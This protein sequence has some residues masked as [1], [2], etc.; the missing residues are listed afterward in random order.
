MRYKGKN[1][2]DVLDLDHHEDPIS[3]W[4][5]FFL[6]P[7]GEHG[8]GS[9]F[10]KSLIEEIYK[11]SSNYGFD[12]K[13]SV[14]IGRNV[15]NK[16]M[17][18]RKNVDIIIEGVH[19][20]K[21][22]AIIIESKIYADKRNDFNYY[23]NIIDLPKEDKICILMTLVRET[24]L[25]QN[26][27]SIT[28]D[29]WMSRVIF[30]LEEFKSD[31]NNFYRQ[32]AL[33]LAKHIRDLSEKRREF[34]KR[35]Q[36]SNNFSN[37]RINK[38]RKYPDWLLSFRRTLANEISS[39]GVGFGQKEHSS[40]SILLQYKE[41][42]IYVFVQI[43]NVYNGKIAIGIAIKTDNDDTWHKTLQKL[44]PF[45]DQKGFNEFRPNWDPKY[46]SARYESYG[47]SKI[48]DKEYFEYK[49]S[50]VYVDAVK[51]AIV[52]LL[53]EDSWIEHVGTISILLSK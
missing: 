28:H 41:T 20:I 15:G 29:E 47:I 25:P 3:D 39:L 10:L 38:K 42:P 34:S 27:I 16:S 21:K 32:K 4:Y 24:T 45:S 44:N 49:S 33:M 22:K 35:Q 8:L 12:I 40:N 18:S 52:S 31:K 7:E 2:I 46:K 23:Y 1:L 5:A 13:Y 36:D 37:D 43:S 30:N 50:N 6:E 51:D 17:G 53:I 14:L 9:L 26:F 19:E 11:A 48:L